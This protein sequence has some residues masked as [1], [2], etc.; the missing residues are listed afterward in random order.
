MNVASGGCFVWVS[1]DAVELLLSLSRQ[2]RCFTPKECQTVADGR[3]IKKQKFAQELF[4]PE[5]GYGQ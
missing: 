5:K 1:F 2:L 4:T 3:L